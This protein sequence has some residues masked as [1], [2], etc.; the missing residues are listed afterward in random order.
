MFGSQLDHSSEMHWVKHDLDCPSSL[1]YIL[2]AKA[3]LQN[4]CVLLNSSKEIKLTGSALP[5]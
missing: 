1:H 2:Q 3:K 4:N 5:L